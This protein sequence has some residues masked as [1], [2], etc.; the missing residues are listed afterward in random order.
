MFMYFLLYDAFDIVSSTDYSTSS[1][2][3]VFDNL[4]DFRNFCGISKGVK[5]ECAIFEIVT[6]FIFLILLSCLMYM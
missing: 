1:F 5:I 6:L 4:K 3:V 2:D